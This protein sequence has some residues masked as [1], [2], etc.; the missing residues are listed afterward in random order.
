[1]LNDLA[2]A[3]EPEDVHGSL[4][5]VAWPVLETVQ[6][7]QV[8]FG[9]RPLHLDPLAGPFARHPLEIID[10]AVLA[11]RDMRV[12]LDVLVAG[13]ALDGRAAGSR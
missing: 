2:A 9:D 8:A 3:V 1:M 4:I 12:V 5:V 11:G 10:E 6:H 7:D 13:I